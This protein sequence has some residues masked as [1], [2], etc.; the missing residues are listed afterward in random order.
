MRYYTTLHYTTSYI[1]P[2]SRQFSPHP[3]PFWARDQK[4][5]DEWQ[6]TH[7]TRGVGRYKRAPLQYLSSLA[8]L[9]K[10]NNLRPNKL[11]IN[12]LHAF[13]SFS[14]RY[15]HFLPSFFIGWFD[16][17]TSLSQNIS[18]FRFIHKD[19]MEIAQFETAQYLSPWCQ[20]VFSGWLM[21]CERAGITWTLEY[22][23]PLSS[24]ITSVALLYIPNEIRTDEEYGIFI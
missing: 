11:T 15:F 23:V 10:D 21:C 1:T 16:V 13:V 24:K 19:P 2:Q 12:S 6:Q 9:H 22:M 7:T 20:K 4:T 3:F 5:L 18:F 14:E 17:L 8:I